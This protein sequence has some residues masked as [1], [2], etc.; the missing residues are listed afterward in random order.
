MNS[1]MI[2]PQV[3]D[4]MPKVLTG[5]VTILS[6]ILLFLIIYYLINIGNRY[7]EKNKRLGIDLK[8][9]LK[10]IVVLIVIF[11][12]RAIFSRYSIVGDTVWALLAGIIVAFVVNPAVTFLE[13]KNVSRKYGVII[14]YF[15]AILIFTLLLT[16]VIPKTIQEISNLL[17]SIP[18]IIEAGSNI[19]TGFLDSISN[20]FNIE[21]STTQQVVTSEVSTQMF[22][23]DIEKII[24][25]FED[26]LLGSLEEFQNRLGDYLR[27]AASGVYVV[28][29]KLIRLVLVFIFSFYFTVDKDKYKNILIRNIPKKYKDDIFY[30]SKKI[31]QALLDFVKG[32]LLMALF[33]GFATMLYLLILG[34]DF[35]IVIGMITCIADIIPYIGPFL[36][37]IPAVLF[38]FIESPIKAVWVG[39]LFVLLQWVENNILAPKLLSDKTGLNPM[40]ILISIIIGGGTFGVFGMILAVPVVS[41]IIILIDFAKMKYNEN[42][43]KLV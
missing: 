8:L 10:I 11:I 43:S 9:V 15:T 20:I 37:F 14:V 4:M 29:S 17:K 13:E 38:A 30:V 26:F 22:T 21:S 35:A 31:N 7:I 19:L 5:A 23:L 2:T 3:S 40:L 33:V 28:F 36:G 27:N 25:S 1:T 34:V 39:V 12:I 24:N 6:I 42:N 16:I 32:R 41:I 18:T